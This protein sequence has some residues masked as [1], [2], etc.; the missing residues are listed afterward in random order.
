VLIRASA[1]WKEG[2]E[3]LRRTGGASISSGEGRRNVGGGRTWMVDH[4]LC[5][6]DRNGRR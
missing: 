3:K 4:E 2:K 5:M 1:F 6:E